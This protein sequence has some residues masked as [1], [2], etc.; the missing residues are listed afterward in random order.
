MPRRWQNARRLRGMAPFTD[1]E[2][3]A[4]EKIF[5]PGKPTGLD[6]L[7]WTDEINAQSLDK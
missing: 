2:W 5:R 6:F 4:L 3:K 7:L 1:R